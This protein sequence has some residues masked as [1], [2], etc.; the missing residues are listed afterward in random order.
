MAGIRMG[1]MKK[2]CALFLTF[3]GFL[4]RCVSLSVLVTR[5]LPLPLQTISLL[6]KC[7]NEMSPQTA[8]RED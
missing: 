1:L 6:T 4:Y 3:M 8:G 2:D 7:T 5:T